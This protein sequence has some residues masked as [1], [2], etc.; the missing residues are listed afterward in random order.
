MT[1]KILYYRRTPCQ[2]PTGNLSSDVDE[3]ILGITKELCQQ[4]NIA[5]YNP[6]SVSWS[7]TVLRGKSRYGPI[8]GTLPW[9]QCVLGNQETDAMILPEAMHDKVEPD[10]WRP[11][12]ASALFYKKKLRRRIVIGAALGALVPIAIVAALYFVL[13]I[14][15]TQPTTLT[16][17]GQ[18]DG[19]VPLGTAIMLT[20]IPL[21]LFFIT[22]GTLVLALIYKKRVRLLA[23]RDAA[24]LVGTPLFLAVLAKIAAL[25]INDLGKTK[26]RRGAGVTGIPTLEQRIID[27]Q[28]YAGKSTS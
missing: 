21:W 5:D 10:D 13:P 8:Y 11:L 19:I 12:I 7:G 2:K 26:H 27:L 24:D 9:D 23:D 15:L 3:R 1:Y 18:P 17:S 20:T 25:D 16:H 28:N 14:L 4:L 22:S 6:T